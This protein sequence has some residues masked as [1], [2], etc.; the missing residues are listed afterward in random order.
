V[1]TAEQILRKGHDYSY[2][3]ARRITRIFFILFSLLFFLFGFLYVG[4][5]VIHLVALGRFDSN[6]LFGAVIMIFLFSIWSPFFWLFLVFL[7]LDIEEY[8]YGINLKFM[9]KKYPIK[10]GEISEIRRARPLGFRIRKDIILVVTNSNLTPF[11]RL[12]GLFYGKTNNP[13]FIV[14][15]ELHDSSILKRKIVEQIKKN[16]PFK[17]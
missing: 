14:P 13:S 9:T 1:V 12:Y 11:H 7:F 15:P 17:N 10:W 5:A 16:K 6:Q 8:E 3:L 4:N 2:G